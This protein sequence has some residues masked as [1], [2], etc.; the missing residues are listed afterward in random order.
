MASDHTNYMASDHTGHMASNHT[1]HMASDH[2]DYMASDHTYRSKD[3]T[4]IIII[5][6]SGTNADF[7]A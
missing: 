4:T 5:T 1:D 6:I 3:V 7:V 2:T